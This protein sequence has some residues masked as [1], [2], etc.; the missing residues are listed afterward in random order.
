MRKIPYIL[1]CLLVLLCMLP[2]AAS[3]ETSGEDRPDPADLRTITCIEDFNAEGVTMGCVTGMIIDQYYEKYMPKADIIY[4]NTVTDLLFATQNGQVD[5]FLDDGPVAKYL[6][7]HTEGLKYLDEQVGDPLETAFIVGSSEFDKTLQKNFNAFIGKV[8]ADGSMDDMVD[9][10]SGTDEERQ[11][12]EYPTEGPNGTIK[13]AIYAESAP[14]CYIKNG[15]PVG[16]EMDLLCRFSKEYGYKLDIKIVDF[17]GML[18]GVTSGVYDMGAGFISVTEERKQSLTFTEPYLSSYP[19]FL[20]RDTVEE[21]S[22]FAGLGESFKRTFIVERRWKLIVQGVLTTLEISVFAAL[23]GTLLGFILCMLRR[24]N[25][26][27]IHGFTTVYIR[28]LQGTPVLVLLMILFYLVLAKSGISG[29]VVAII[30]FSL[31]FAAYVCE[32]FRTGI[33]SVDRGQ[34]EAA[35]ALGYTKSQTFFKIILPQ[36][37]MHFLPV[38]KGEFISLVKMTSVVG[39]IAVQDLTKMSDIIRS[40]TYEAFFPLI[41]SAVIYFLLAAL[42]TSILTAIEIKVRPD[43]KNRMPKGVKVDD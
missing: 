5:G 32:M 33:D 38:Y 29:T 6:A 17:A 27:L 39:Y 26:K 4:F 14:S 3:A 2:T 24:M 15:Q 13:L 43:R 42:L 8:K 34:S 11:V 40:R 12:L 16:F 9:L 20:V 18:S 25:N 7:S 23:F 35:L 36:A 31:N 41:A 10:W 30:A 22:F 1:S 19:L 37:A 21:K 28:I